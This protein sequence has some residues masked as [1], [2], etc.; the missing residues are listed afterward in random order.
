MSKTFGSWKTSRLVTHALYSGALA[1][2]EGP[3]VDSLKLPDSIRGKLVQKTCAE[4]TSLGWNLL[5]RGLWPI[6]W[7]KAQEYEFSRSP[8]HRG[9]TDNGESWASR[10]QGW[11][12]DLFDD[13]AWGL[14]NAD[15]H[16][17][18]LDTQRMIRLAKCECAIRRLYR[19]GKSLPNHKRHPFRDPMEVVLTKTVCAQERWVSM[20]EEYL[21]AAK[22]LVKARKKKSQRS[23][24]KFF[25]QRRTSHISQ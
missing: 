11:M 14:R 15:E 16:G 4:Q 5:F 20:A 24:Q 7:R 23:L 3:T 19:A 17:A 21:P 2:I 6:Y 10:A 18:D 13:L 1:W 25:G 22:R 12:F 9:H 8:L